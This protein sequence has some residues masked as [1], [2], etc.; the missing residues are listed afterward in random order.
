MLYCPLTFHDTFPSGNQWAF[1]KIGVW[2]LY[3]ASVSFCRTV[4][5]IGH[6]VEFNSVQFSRSMCSLR[7][8]GLQHSRPP[9]PSPAPGACSDSCPSSQWC[10]PAISSSV[11]PFASYPQSFPAS[12]SFQWDSS[13]HQVAQVLKFQLQ[14]QSLQWTPRT[15]WSPLGWTA[16]I[17]LQS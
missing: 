11:V 6:S 15:D 4:K 8:Q 16:W 17:S 9:C 12:G 3:N 1:W 2:L 14:H 10:H 7:P 5:W 13:S